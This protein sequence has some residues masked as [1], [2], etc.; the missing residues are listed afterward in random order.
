MRRQARAEQSGLVVGLL[1]RALGSYDDREFSI[2]APARC[3]AR[4]YA[5]RRGLDSYAELGSE[6]AAR[7]Q[8]VLGPAGTTISMRLVA[9]SIA[10]DSVILKSSEK[11]SLS[12]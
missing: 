9:R 11:T 6:S 7:L 1:R 8:P 4:A 3:R 12:G 10:V 5:I 2:H